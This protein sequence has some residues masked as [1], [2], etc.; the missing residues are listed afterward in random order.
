M[1]NVEQKSFGSSRTDITNSLSNSKA[2]WGQ[3]YSLGL[4]FLWW[5]DD[6][7]WISTS[8]CM[9]TFSYSL[10]FKIREIVL[11][12]SKD[13]K[14]DIFTFHARMWEICKTSRAL[15]LPKC[16]CICVCVCSIFYKL[17]FACWSRQN[18]LDCI[19]WSMDVSKHN[20]FQY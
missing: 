10:F 6:N 16:V 5:I 11:L 18:H 9:H 12:F 20:G 19:N 15:I 1:I 4:F 13:L 17:S 3:F 8:F 7:V 14:P 2:A